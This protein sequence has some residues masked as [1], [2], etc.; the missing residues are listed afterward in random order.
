MSK[1]S[2]FNVNE[3]FFARSL[4]FETSCVNIYDKIDKNVFIV[5]I[6][7][8]NYDNI[9]IKNEIRYCKIFENAD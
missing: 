9:D 4:S 1:Y 3:V 6:N 8:N 5:V 2:L 7:N